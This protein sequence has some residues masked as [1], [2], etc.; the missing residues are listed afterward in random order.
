[1]GIYQPVIQKYAETFGPVGSRTGDGHRPARPYRAALPVAQVDTFEFV[2]DNSTVY[3]ITIEGIVFTVAGTVGDA[4]AIAQAFVADIMAHHTANQ[5][6]RPV[7][8]GSGGLTLTA[9]KPGV[10]FTATAGV[11]GGA[12]TNT[13]TA[14]TANNAGVS[15]P[16]GAPVFRAA[17]GTNA[18]LIR[19]PTDDTDKFVGVVQFRHEPV[20]LETSYSGF[21]YG[22][23]DQVPVD[24]DGAHIVIASTGCAPNDPVHVVKLTG[25]YRNSG[26]TGQVTR[27]TVAANPADSVNMYI[28]IRNDVTGEVYQV[29]A[30][31]DGT[32]TG[33]EVRD[34]FG[35]FINANLSGFTSADVS[36]DAIDITGPAGVPFTVIEGNAEITVANQSLGG[37]VLLPGAY[38]DSVATAGQ[39]AVMIHHVP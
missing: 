18:G 1:M 6:V 5:I 28:Q 29:P 36:T 31:A 27:V 20:E 13:R 24:P 33:T 38:W 2:D 25:A 3:S 26:L 11:A 10:G 4:D 15:L 8:D 35:D 14:T 32:S 37:T 7:F 17:N 23:G 22:P 19:L 39:K 16:A 34:A 9:R 21:A 30:A 12:G